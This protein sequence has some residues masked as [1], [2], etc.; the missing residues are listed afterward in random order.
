M[1][2]PRTDTIRRAWT[3]NSGRLAGV[4]L[5]RSVIGHAF[6][7]RADSIEPAV[8]TAFRSGLIPDGYSPTTAGRW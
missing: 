7:G 8:L 1:F 5:A 3:R 6:G 2:T 4:G